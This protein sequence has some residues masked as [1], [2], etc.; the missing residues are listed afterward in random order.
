MLLSRAKR[1][2]FVVEAVEAEVEA[3][4]VLEPKLIEDEEEVLLSAKPL[5]VLLS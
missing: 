3:V 2:L 4:A 1:I 5:L